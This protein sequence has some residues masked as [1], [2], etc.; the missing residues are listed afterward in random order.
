MYI[1]LEEAKKHLNIEQDFNEDNTYILYL[2]EVAEA[3]VARYICQPLIDLEDPTHHIPAPVKHAAMLYMGDLYNSREGNAYGV[4]V[5]QVP[6]TFQFL[7][8]AWRCYADVTSDQFTQ[9][10]LDDILSRMYVNDDGNLIIRSS[11]D[12]YQGARG[13]ALK[14]IEQNFI[15]NGGRLYNVTS[16]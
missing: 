4:N 11:E 6:F 14:R 5:S 1:T 3:V 2:I 10:C 7:C 16:I 13:K 12:M 9:E 15:Q 8:D